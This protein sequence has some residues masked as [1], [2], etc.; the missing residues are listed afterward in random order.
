M[1]ILRYF[2]IL[3]M[4]VLV[5]GPVW[6][7]PV[8]D[9]A[10]EEPQQTLKLAYPLV[11]RWK[12]TSLYDRTNPN[13]QF[14][15]DNT[16][17]I[18]TGATVRRD[19]NPPGDFVCDIFGNWTVCAYTDG[20][21]SLWNLRWDQDHSG[22][23]GGPGWL[24][25]DSRAGYDIAANPTGQP[26][27]AA[28]DGIAHH[29]PLYQPNGVRVDHP[30][31]YHTYYGHNTWWIADNTPVHYGTHIANSGQAGGGPHLHFGVK[32]NALNPVD[33]GWEGGSLWAGDIWGGD[34]F[35]MGY[36]DQNDAPHGPFQLDNTAIRNAWIANARKLGSP[37]G[38]D[39]SA[40]CPTGDTQ[41]TCCYQ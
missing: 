7:R 20:D 32:D 15:L 16:I 35:P 11:R 27:A 30:N 9:S 33:P 29:D 8:G 5:P 6:P 17:Q 34:P 4:L 3:V 2:C 39:F 1:C 22:A 19:G 14:N 13:D 26:V 21:T 40:A 36:V 25:Y 23:S 18:Y 41:A 10:A 37:I 24:W 28:G 38:E 12:L 31:G